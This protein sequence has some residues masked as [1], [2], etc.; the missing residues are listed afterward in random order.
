MPRK[1]ELIAASF[2]RRNDN[3]LRERSGEEGGKW[4]AHRR[5]ARNGCATKEREPEAYAR[6]GAQAEAY[7]TVADSFVDKAITGPV[8]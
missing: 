5:T 7:A 1:I 4:T 2:P 8:R 3:W 6:K